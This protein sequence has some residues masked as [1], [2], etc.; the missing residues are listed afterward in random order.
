MF[1]EVS[2]LLNRQ[3]NEA[4]AV[5]ESEGLSI[6]AGLM[7]AV[8]RQDPNA[9][10]AL[11]RIIGERI[12]LT[13]TR[14]GDLAVRGV[15]E[16]LGL[17]LDELAVADGVSDSRGYLIRDRLT[18]IELAQMVGASRVAVN[19]ALTELRRSGQIIID[20]RRIVIPHRRSG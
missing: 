2:L 16:R 19:R 11:G 14:L 4:R 3:I 9:V 15:K 6:D 8:L 18:Q 12:A 7:R 13:E 10:A 5:Q 1:G 17:V 20:G